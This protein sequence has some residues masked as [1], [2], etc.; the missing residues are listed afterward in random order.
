MNSRH[1]Q[2]TPSMKEEWR[3]LPEVTWFGIYIV[4]YS[5]FAQWNS[6]PTL[7]SFALPA[8]GEDHRLQIPNKSFLEVLTYSSLIDELKVLVRNTFDEGVNDSS[9]SHLFLGF[10]SYYIPLAQP[11]AIPTLSPLHL[12]LSPF[13][14]ASVVSSATMPL[15]L[16]LRDWVEYFINPITQ[17]DHSGAWWIGQGVKGPCRHCWVHCWHFL[18]WCQFHPLKTMVGYGGICGR[19]GWWW[20]D[21]SKK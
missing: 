20:R 2:E 8:C 21:N 1:L 16:T 7:V 3:L 17:V 9:R 12:Q 14:V 4:L 10:V 15:P 11:N 5:P 18:C 19:G 13:V 6:I